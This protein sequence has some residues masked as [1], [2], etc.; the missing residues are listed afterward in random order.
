MRNS[1]LMVYGSSYDR[2]VEHLLKMWP[3][4]KKAVPEAELHVFYGWQLFDIGYADNPERMAWKEKINDL[5]KQDGITHLG[6]IS[7]EALQKEFENAGVWAY[8]THFG[9]ISC[10]TA[11][12]AQAYGAIPC[13]IDYA[14][15]KETVQ[16]G[17]K[18]KG[19]IY[20]QETKDL[21]KN[22]LIGLLNDE[23]YQENVRKEMI[24]WARKKFGWSNIAKQWDEEFRKEYLPKPKSL[25]KQVEEL[26]DDNQ[27]LKA[28]ELVKD[29]DSPL[30][31]RIWLRIRHAF[32]DK[33]YEKY[34]V[35]DL[36][37]NFVTEEQALDCTT[38]APRFKWMV[39]RILNNKPKNLIDLGCADG[40]LCITLAN[41]GI[42]CIGVNLHS[43][44]VVF[45]RERAKKLKLD[46]ITGFINKNIFEIKDKTDCVVMTEVLEHLPDPQKGVDHAMNMLNENGRAFFSSPRTDH[47]G[48]EM[49]K[50]EP[51]HEGWDDG[52][53]SGHL[54]LFTEEEFK[55]LFDKYEIIEY[56]LDDERCMNVEVRL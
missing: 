50:R 21:Y 22:A 20:D 6:R 7:H 45:A 17:V 9:E 34:Y 3:D 23:E 36:I 11:M 31:E 35:E 1:K 47:I 28:W 32:D 42:P 16:Y 4:I 14:A 26:M 37:E 25:E 46:E 53:P 44:S 48:V 38:L 52:K 8:P 10:I 49:H 12:K 43:A 2:G 51:N 30:K 40:Y 33:L 19:D 27:A 15:L 24:P 5:M 13:V 39:P 29:T 56:Y 18:I 41:K 54:R 55:K